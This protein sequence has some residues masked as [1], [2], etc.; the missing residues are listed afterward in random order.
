M[1]PKQLRTLTCGLLLVLCVGTACSASLGLASGKATLR[2]KA[3]KTTTSTLHLRGGSDA[4]GEQSA[5]EAV[6]VAGEEEAM[7]LEAVSDPADEP[8]AEPDPNH[9]PPP[10]WPTVTRSVSYSA[11][12]DTANTQF[13]RSP[14]Q[15]PE[16]A[17]ERTDL[18]VGEN[19]AQAAPDLPTA[20]PV[21]AQAEPVVIVEETEEE[22][23]ARLEEEERIA[24]I[25][26][27]RLKVVIV[28]SEVAPWSKSGGLADVADK[29]SVALSRR[30][31]RVMTVAPS[32]THYEGAMPTEI[33]RSFTLYGGTHEV[34]YTHMW[35]PTEVGG[36]PNT[37]KIGVDRIFVQN[38]CFER[39]G[40][41]GDPGG[42][43][44]FDNMFRFALFS[45]AAVEAPLLLPSVAPFGEKVI[46]IANDWQ[47]GLVPLI[48]ASHY[49]RW[50]VYEPARCLFIIHNMGYQGNFPNPQMYN[51]DLDDPRDTPK[52][53]FQD[54]GLADNLLYDVYKYVF[55]EED[56]G[57][58]GEVDDGEC[59]KLLM[60]AI[61]IA[62]RIVTVS[63]SYKE[64]VMT[65]GGWGLQEKVRC[66][67]S[68]FDGILNGIDTNEW[69]PM[70][71]K[72]LVGK[73]NVEN[74]TGKALCK[75][76]I[77]ASLGLNVNPDVP[78]IA[79]IGRLA[80]QKGID[81]LEQSFN[82]IMHSGD[83]LDNS[84]VIMM[85]S[86]DPKYAEF[87]RAM[88]AQYK[89]RVCGYV[90]FSSEIEHKIIAGADIILM[91]SRYEPCG[92]PQMYAQRYGTIPVVHATGGL[93][94]SVDQYEPPG[95]DGEES[96]GTGWK[97]GNCDSGGLQWGIHNALTV[98]KKNPKDW[99][100]VVTRAM[101]KDF[102]W[103]K[104]AEKY[105][106]IFD[107]VQMDEPVQR[108]W[109]FVHH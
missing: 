68:R 109:P 77:Q 20:A 35:C 30:G 103:D 49:R 11:L 71:D 94:D 104:S 29:L 64:E 34:H 1:S 67:Q 31:H 73:Y 82:W 40:M 14:S 93:K 100:A 79:F 60:G 54:L 39:A 61:H 37:T 7:S 74:R 70:T 107:W 91:P 108:P 80:P 42:H 106:Q 98:Y 27:A 76:D 43:E 12:D 26:G 84:Q 75:A 28:S 6:E 23:A 83:V 66:R 9:V 15:I 44:Y 8:V 16:E 97:F 13:L 52:W 78:L 69:D 36:D 96:K 65:T 56:R 87:M 3:S 102:S 95:E 99:E 2:L 18:K 48:I 53:S 88:E 50:R 101:S 38:G 32:Y 46:F 25:E 105:E 51:Y 81:V 72:H 4:G 89:G 47:T 10:T 55:P 62:D 85:G 19:M 5:E 92:L 58:K 63:P 57:D 41:Y 17:K 45:W 21:V 33:R 22:I 90:G 24:A 86:G 59:C